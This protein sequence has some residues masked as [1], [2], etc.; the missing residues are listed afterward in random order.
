MK[1]LR[2]ARQGKRASRAKPAVNVLRE[3]LQLDPAGV[4]EVAQATR[5]SPEQVSNAFLFGQA[6]GYL[7]ERDGRVRVTWRWLRPILRL[8]E[9]RHL[10]VNP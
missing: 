3:G 5:L 7:S 8:L 1:G 10:L 9:R 6:H 2:E 4:A